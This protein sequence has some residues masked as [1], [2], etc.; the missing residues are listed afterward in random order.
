[1]ALHPNRPVRKMRNLIVLKGCAVT[2]GGTAMLP[3]G[4]QT[5]IRLRN[6]GVL[7]PFTY[8]AIMKGLCS[9]LP[10]VTDEH[11]L[12]LPVQL[13]RAMVNLR[14]NPQV[15]RD[16]EIVARI[17][18]LLEA[19][20]RILP[21][22]FLAAVRG[23]LDAYDGKRVPG[24]VMRYGLLVLPASEAQRYGIPP[25]GKEPD[26][27]KVILFGPPPR[28]SL[29]QEPW[30]YPGGYTGTYME[31]WY[32]LLTAEQQVDALRP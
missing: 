8:Y 9:D 15:P 26:P 17:Y 20:Q 5:A 10:P 28:L 3:E 31:L 14:M 24:E 13:Y 1:M 29:R 23:N 6:E 7:E 25:T 27:N 16:S 11:E 18:D 2:K 32:N 19:N 12:D 22:E 4:I 21:A 30:V